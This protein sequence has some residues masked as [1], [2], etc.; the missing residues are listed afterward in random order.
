MRFGLNSRKAQ[1]LLVFMIL[2]LITNGF[3]D[4]VVF[5]KR[6]VSCSAVHELLVENSSDYYVKILGKTGYK[7]C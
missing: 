3:L 5:Q 1:I 2:L 6:H 7:V 4:I